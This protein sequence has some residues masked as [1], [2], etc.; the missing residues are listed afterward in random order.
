VDGNG[1]PVEIA[2]S[3]PEPVL[4][5]YKTL[6]EAHIGE[7][8]YFRVY[9]GTI[10]FGTDL[11]N[12]DRSATERIGQIFVLNGK[13]RFF[14]FFSFEGLRDGVPIEAAEGF[15]LA[16]VPTPAQ[17]QGDFSALL[18]VGSAYT[19]YDPATSTPSSTAPPR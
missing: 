6:G 17:R 16:T 15:H 19:I 13:N 8:S 11:L 12:S 7:M 9:A 5:V 10:K 2:L 4:Y 14:W 1:N 3:S 18:K